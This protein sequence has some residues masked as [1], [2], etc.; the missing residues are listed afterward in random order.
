M[1]VRVSYTVEVDEAVLRGIR[2][3]K[4]E[5]GVA[6]GREVKAYLEE[7]GARALRRIRWTREQ[8]QAERQ[9]AREAKERERQEKREAKEREREQAAAQLRRTREAD[10]IYFLDN[11]F[12]SHTICGWCGEHKPCR[13]KRR[14]AMACHECYIENGAPT[15]GAV[16]AA[17]S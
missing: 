13:G 1:K 10:W 16:K 9:S 12:S 2:R 17:A 11:G 4:G 5:K 8:E 14:S 3:Q 6:Q 7:Q 15:A